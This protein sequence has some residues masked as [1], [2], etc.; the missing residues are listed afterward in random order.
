M[1]FGGRHRQ[2]RARLRGIRWAQRVRD[3]LQHGWLVLG[4]R[5][6]GVAEIRF[7]GFQGELVVLLPG[8]VSCWLWQCQFQWQLVVEELSWDEVVGSLISGSGSGS[9]GL[10]VLG[11]CSCC[12][13]GAWRWPECPHLWAKVAA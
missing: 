6:G 12:C 3:W 13:G 1:W 7:V 10:A 5:T 9:A 2:G 8:V 4:W 11:C